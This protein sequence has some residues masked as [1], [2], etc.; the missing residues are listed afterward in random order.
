MS[1][2]T[3]FALSSPRVAFK[4]KPHTLL[5]F[6]MGTTNLR[7]KW[8]DHI[9]GLL[10]Q[11]MSEDLFAQKEEAVI[12]KAPNTWAETM[13]EWNRMNTLNTLLEETGFGG[14]LLAD[15]SGG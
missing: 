3:L 10:R 9:L 12:A 2:H 14:L 7:E 1:A 8:L 15:G 11:S 6:A 13:C 5:Q 4:P